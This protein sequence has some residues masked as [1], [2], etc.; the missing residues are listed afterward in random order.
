MEKSI[1]QILQLD[2]LKFD[3]FSLFYQ[4]INTFF[5]WTAQNFPLFLSAGSGKLGTEI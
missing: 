3:S 1:C 2:V 5:T 4:E